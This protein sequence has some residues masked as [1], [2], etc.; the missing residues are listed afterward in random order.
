MKQVSKEKK[1][2]ET[3]GSRGGRNFLSH[4]TGKEPRRRREPPNE[5][6]VTVSVG[7]Q[8]IRLLLWNPLI[9][10]VTKHEVIMYGRGG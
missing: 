7:Y 2:P 9:L 8:K 5:R 3:D 4:R 1:N 10:T 6:D